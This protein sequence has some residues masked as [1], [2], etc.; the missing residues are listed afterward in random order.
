MNN[1]ID[2][3]IRKI[4]RLLDDGELKSA[5]KA[6]IE[7]LTFDPDNLQVIRLKRKIE[8]KV[9]KINI[10][11]IKADMKMLMGLWKEKKIDQLMP[12]LKTLE[13]YINDY[14]PLRRMF[15]KANEEY[16]RFLLN[17]QDTILH[18]QI[19]QVRQMMDENR[20]EEAERVSFQLKS[21][22]I[23]QALV[24]KLIIE[25]IHRWIEYELQKNSELLHSDRYEETMML[26]QRLQNIAP[27][28]NKIKKM[29][30]ETKKKIFFHK[31][32]EK[33]D[34]INRGLEE[35]D[36]LTKSGKF[37]DALLAIQEILQ[38]DPK[39]EKANKY[40]S[41]TKRKLKKKIDEEVISQLQNNLPHN[42]QEYLENKKNFVKI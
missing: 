42:K 19:Q 18:Q 17:Q 16:R 37:E 4:K 23:E 10:K 11:A 24:E 7:L 33:K 32:E 9:K 12:Q 28:D 2:E 29:I 21:L 15:L 27:T 20:Y 13:P 34:F 22:D 41:S 31:I 26:L 36:R 14:G 8:D 5:H 1:A 40:A 3:A 35:I 39:N 38:I 30:D 25:L 6:C